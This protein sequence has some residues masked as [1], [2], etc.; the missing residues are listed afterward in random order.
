MNREG[1]NNVKFFIGPEVEQTPAYS[2]RTLFV[3]DEQ[4]LA[5]IEKYAREHKVTHVFLGA[6]HSFNASREAAPYW[7]MIIT[8]LLSRGYWVTLDYQAHDHALV[9]EM[10]A[11]SIWKCRTFVPLVG[12]RL[13][14]FQTASPNLTVKIDDQDFNST[15]AGVWCLHHNELADSNRFTSWNDYATDEVITDMGTVTA[16]EFNA[17]D[18]LV[19]AEPVAVQTEE[20][21]EKNDPEIGLDPTGESM[22][23]GDT[24]VVQ[25][26]VDGGSSTVE[27]AA[28]LYA[29]AATVPTAEVKKPKSKK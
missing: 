4:P 24:E 3:V 10:L 17:N 20:L 15:N 2:K 21:V 13:P 12:V 8:S 29:D 18:G 5:D 11:D 14:H 1:H 27:E 6:N 22:L 23:K 7:N 28:E 16:E 26:V 25:E 19:I 9:Y